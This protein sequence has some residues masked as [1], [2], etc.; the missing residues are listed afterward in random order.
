[1]IMLLLLS[2]PSRPTPFIDSSKLA[3]F[4]PVLA[5]HNG[6]NPTRLK[7]IPGTMPIL[8]MINLVW[9]SSCSSS[10]GDRIRGSVVVVVVM[11]LVGGGW[12]LVLCVVDVDPFSLVLLIKCVDPH[13]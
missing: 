1:M 5:R 8:L 9:T 6:R 7:R 12:Q 2:S 13:Q 3:R 10:P 4:V 11:D